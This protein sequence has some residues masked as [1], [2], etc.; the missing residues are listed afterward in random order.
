MHVSASAWWREVRWPLAVFAPIL[1]VF[2][3]YDL[4]SA[5]A[6]AL[7][8]DAA[9]QRWLGTHNW[10]VESF[11]HTG[12]RWAIRVV[13]LLGLALWIAASI[14][15]SAQAVAQARRLLHRRNGAWHRRDR[16]AENGDERGLPLGSAAVRRA[17]SADPPVCRPSRRVACSTL[18]SRS[19]CQLRLRT[20]C[21]ILRPSRASS[22][23]G[24]RYIVHGHRLRT[25]LR[26][27]AAV[28]RRALRVARPVERAADLADRIGRLCVRLCG[29]GSQL[30]PGWSERWNDGS[31]TH[32]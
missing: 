13:V 24:A 22:R 8:F 29:S 17:L 25:C 32:S 1:I 3:L 30:R 9:Q 19:A 15:A 5:I 21:S 18:L 12:G 20:C 2:A 4:D 10:W 14:D 31:G 16:T 28:A 6:N 23:R 7:F 27:C 26:H 11:L